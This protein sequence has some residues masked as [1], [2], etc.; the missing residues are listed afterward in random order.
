M[1]QLSENDRGDVGHGSCCA[2]QGAAVDARRSRRQA[3]LRDETRRAAR[4]ERH[5]DTLVTLR[6]GRFLMGT[7]DKVGFPDDAEGPVREVT[8]SPF[9]VDKFPVTNERFQEF[10]RATGYVTEAEEFGWSFVF[11]NFVPRVLLT[12]GM[13]R[14]VPGLEWW[15]AVDR[16]TWFK[17]EGKGSNIRTRMDHPVVHITWRDADRYCAWA[18]L[19]LPTEAEWEYAARGGLVGKRY[20]WGDELT[21]NGKHMCNIWQGDFPAR[22]TAADGFQG[23]CPV[24][25]FSPNGFGLYTVA[26][27]VWEWCADFWSVD[28]RAGDPIIDPT[29]PPTGQLRV[30]RGGS[31]LCHSSYCNRYRVAARTSNTPDSSTGNLGFRCVA[32]A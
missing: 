22:N 31:Y 11:R 4:G 16:A 9:R 7:N 1:S 27:N 32:D 18:G 13:A 25:S 24:K 30:M 3:E 8:I 29:G 17:P 15:Y 12:R 14:T 28:F 5:I 6:A 10:V 2:P 19:R 23:T 21:P 26:G 20:V